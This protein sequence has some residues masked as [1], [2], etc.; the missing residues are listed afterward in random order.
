MIPNSA[1]MAA[2]YYDG[3]NYFSTPVVAWSADGSPL[4]PGD[5]SC[6]AKAS[7]VHQG[8]TYVGLWRWGW[9]PSASQMQ[10]TRR[11]DG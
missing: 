6:L 4:T 11:E 7:V 2:V 8:I 5:N 1:P 9:N 10:A 3:A